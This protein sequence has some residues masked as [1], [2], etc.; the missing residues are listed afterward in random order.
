MNVILMCDKKYWDKKMSRVRFHAMEAIS[1]H[2]SMNVIMD[3]PG[4][5]GWVD[6]PTSVK[7][8]NADVVFWY[9]PLD[10]LG[11]DK[12][13]VTKVISYNEMWDVKWTTDEITKSKSDIVICHHN[14]DIKNY[15]HLKDKCKLINIPHCAEKTIFKDYGHPKVYDVL[16]VGV[17]SPTIYPLRSV[18]K[19]II[20][21]GMLRGYNVKILQHPGYRI[22]DVNAQVKKY[23]EEINKAKLVLSCSSKYDYVLAKY[24]EVPLCNSL[25][26]ADMPDEREDFFKQYVIRAEVKDGPDAI[27]TKIKWWLS[28]DTERKA[29]TKLGRELIE[30][31][32]TQEHYADMFYKY[33]GELI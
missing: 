9:K 23:A 2:P 31:N 13:D 1:R 15:D 12:V 29:V 25:L 16:L 30:S 11:Y 5:Q 33:I 14:N 20:D 3:G 7:K 21:K 6:A 10:I 32:F 22:T 24:T 26:M 4:F 19:Y 17:I 8:H 27:A 18:F 28:H